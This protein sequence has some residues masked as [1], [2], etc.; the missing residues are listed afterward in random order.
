MRPAHT[1]RVR[2]VTHAPALRARKATAG[3]DLPGVF[4]CTILRALELPRTHREVF[5]LGD[6]QGHTLQEI[7]GILGISLET[8]RLRLERAR[9]EIGQ[10]ADS[11]AG[12]RAQ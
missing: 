2:S 12:G 7:A 1:A 3:F 9:R 5:L 6:I 8:A 10:L 11:D 4:Q